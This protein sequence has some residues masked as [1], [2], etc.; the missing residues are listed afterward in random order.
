M[1]DIQSGNRQ[2]QSQNSEPLWRQP[3]PIIGITGEFASGK[4]LF[5]L[6]IDPA[7]TLLY[8]TEQSALSYESLGFRRVDVPHEL[9]IAHPQGYRP[10]QVYEWWVQHVRSIAPGAYR[11]IALDTISELEAGLVEW[12]R[13][14]PQH[15]GHTQAQYA[16]MSALVW[17]DAKDLWKAILTDISA[18][19]ETLVFASHLTTVWSGE[20]P[21][22]KRKP[23]GKV[24]LL[25]LASLYVHLE[26]RPD[27]QGK[28]PDKP[29]A[30]VLKSRLASMRPN[31]QTG[32]IEIIPTL[33]PRL[34]VATPHAIRQYMLRP[35][36]YSNL[37]ADELAPEPA[38]TDDERAEL[39]LATA[40][41]ERDAEA[42][43]L[44]RLERQQAAAGQPAQPALPRTGSDAGAR[45][46]PDKIR[47][48]EDCRK[49][50]CAAGLT[51][52]RW[53]AILGAYGVM[54][55]ADLTAQQG[56]ELLDRCVRK[57]TEVNAC[58][59]HVMQQQEGGDGADAPAKS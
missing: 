21:T 54:A 22:G 13:S 51:D 33:P 18:R 35:P 9:L 36:N 45:I 26:R 32:E 47:T 8:D 17:G 37:Q 44:Q 3:I 42:L 24:T 46:S 27:K 53:Q 58:K 28:V 57:L 5:A 4:T 20:R 31:P 34:P 12:V 39:R 19:C 55:L 25:E 49:E 16:R 7:K 59:T 11:V 15:F 23:K 56:D 14:N 10:I 38:L 1:V 29:S 30:T 43:R 50:L 40:E 6:S 2:A 52:N 41:A 48:I